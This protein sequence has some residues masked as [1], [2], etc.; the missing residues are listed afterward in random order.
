MNNEHQQPEQS[1]AALQFEIQKLKHLLVYVKTLSISAIKNR[2][3][4][5][6]GGHYKSNEVSKNF[7]LNIKASKEVKLLSDAKHQIDNPTESETKTFLEAIYGSSQDLVRLGFSYA[8]KWKNNR[9][10]CISQAAGY[11]KDIAV[12]VPESNS[13]KFL[14]LFSK[15]FIKR[16]EKFRQN[17]LIKQ[18][19]PVKRAQITPVNR[20]NS[21]KTTAVALEASE[22][23][24]LGSNNGME[25]LNGIVNTLLKSNLPRVSDQLGE[26]SLSSKKFGLYPTEPPYSAPA[27]PKKCMEEKTTYF[28]IK[29]KRSNGPNLSTV[30]IPNSSPPFN[31]PQKMEMGT[32]F[33]F[34]KKPTLTPQKKILLTRGPLCG[35]KLHCARIQNTWDYS[36]S[37]LLRYNLRVTDICKTREKENTTSFRHDSHKRVHNKRK[38]QS[39]RFEVYK[40][41]NN[42]RGQHR[43]IGRKIGLS[44]HITQ[45][46]FHK[47]VQILAPKHGHRKIGNNAQNCSG[48]SGG[49][50]R[51]SEDDHSPNSRKNEKNPP[52]SSPGTPPTV[53]NKSGYGYKRDVIRSSKCNNTS[54][55]KIPGAPDGYLKSTN[56]ITLP[57]R[58]PLPTIRKYHKRSFMMGRADK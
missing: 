31:A 27:Q 5:P 10:V 58:L 49:S 52:G 8:H 39:E 30:R 48:I 2:H 9:R 55:N 17:R 57:A 53:Y 24:P 16:I 22:A 28:T 41:L 38:L 40:R 47:N 13:P 15:N 1:I 6:N 43:K 32:K 26:E 11:D 12:S 34:T 18:A 42:T 56:Q 29:N 21:I 4:A 35:Q 19:S 44:P 51:H 54:I 25:A 45:P 36:K 7:K 50:L 23:D 3:P 33:R 37:K 14:N 46:R 20:T